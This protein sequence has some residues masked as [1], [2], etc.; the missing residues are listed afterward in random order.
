MYCIQQTQG[1]LP[2]C[3]CQLLLAGFG[4]TL[5]VPWAHSVNHKAG[6]QLIAPAD[7]EVTDLTSVLRIQA[8]L[9]NNY[10]VGRSGGLCN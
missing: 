6:R 8:L 4:F 2:V 10:G 3:L 1:G 7:R 9:L 5:M